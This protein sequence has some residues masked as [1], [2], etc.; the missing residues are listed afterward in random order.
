MGKHV[1]PKS[2]AKHVRAESEK[3][4]VKK[5][6]Q[7]LPDKESKMQGIF[8]HKGRSEGAE[9]KQERRIEPE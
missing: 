4:S 1:A 8:Q 6:V 7:D 5:R 3:K 2:S 9:E